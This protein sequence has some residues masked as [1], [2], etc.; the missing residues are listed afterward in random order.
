MENA[1]HHPD[2]PLAPHP[3][4]RWCWKVC[5]KLHYFG[6]WND[7]QDALNLWLTQKDDVLAGRTPSRGEGSP[8]YCDCPITSAALEDTSNKIKTLRRHAYG[9]Q[10]HEFCKL[11]IYALHETTCVFVG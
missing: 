5:G 8:A 7:P 9:F 2:F 10:D 3:A 6:P 11:T 1:R 4:G